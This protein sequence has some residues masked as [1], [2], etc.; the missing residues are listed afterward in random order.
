MAAAGAIFWFLPLF[1]YLAQNNIY[2]DNFLLT[3]YYHPVM[4]SLKVVFF[5]ALQKVQMNLDEQLI[6]QVDE[7]AATLHVNRTAA[8]SV[9]L[10][11]ALQADK[12]AADLSELMD[13]YRV[14]S[15]KIPVA[16]DELGAAVDR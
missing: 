2:L 6:K 10:S 5:M 12:L 4:I 8:V 3:S 15:G 16:I 9:L 14:Q 7:Y 11:R 1:R 13:A